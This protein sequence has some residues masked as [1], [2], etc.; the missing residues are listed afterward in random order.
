MHELQLVLKTDGGFGNINWYGLALISLLLMYKYL[1]HY[2]QA[3][4]D[5]SRRYVIVQLCRTNIVFD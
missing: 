5:F 3:D 1:N 2:L 4:E